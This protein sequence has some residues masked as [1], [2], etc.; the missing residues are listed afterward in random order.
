[1]KIGRADLY[2]VLKVVMPDKTSDAIC[3][4]WTKWR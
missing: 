2:A 3:G 1:M 4:Y